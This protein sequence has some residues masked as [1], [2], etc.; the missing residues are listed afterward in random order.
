MFVSPLYQKYTLNFIIVAD[1][2][3]KSRENGYIT[4]EVIK[5]KNKKNKS[6]VHKD[7]VDL[8]DDY[9]IRQN[10]N[11]NKH[12]KSAPNNNLFWEERSNPLSSKGN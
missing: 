7:T 12:N 5:M 9:Q 4:F 10:S 1:W 6:H 11:Y 3:E 8:T 2:K